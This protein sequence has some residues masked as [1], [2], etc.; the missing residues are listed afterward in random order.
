MH[1]HSVARDCLLV[2]LFL[3]LR[4]AHTPLCTPN[5]WHL[6]RHPVFGAE[7]E[8]LVSHPVASFANGSN[9]GVLEIGLGPCLM[10]RPLK[11]W[12]TL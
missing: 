6:C 9:V 5:K 8:W 3:L 11:T 2:L 10:S 12:P 1:L 7:L 4:F